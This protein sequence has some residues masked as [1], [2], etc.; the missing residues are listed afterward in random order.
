MPNVKLEDTTLSLNTNN[1]TCFSLEPFSFTPNGKLEDTTLS[2][3][4]NN[5]ICFSLAPFSFTR[6]GTHELEDI[7]KKLE[8]FKAQG[9]CC[10]NEKLED[11]T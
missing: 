4:T 6:P 5:S 3:S 2:P 8:R 11:T 1:S 9:H 7:S 10:S